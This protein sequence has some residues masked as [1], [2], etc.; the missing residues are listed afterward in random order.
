MKFIFLILFMLVSKA[1]FSQESR[2]I[3]IEWEPVEDAVNYEVELFEEEND[4]KTPRGKFKVESSTWSNAVPPGKYSLRIRSLDKRGVP[5]EW[6]EFIPVKVRMQNPRLFQPVPGSKINTPE[7]NF[8][9]SE[10]D[11]AAS[12]QLVVKNGEGKIVHNNLVKDLR[13]SLYLDDLGN[14]SWV[15][16]ALEENEALRPEEEFLASGFKPFSRVGGELDPPE[17]KVNV[18]GKVSITWQKI[19]GARVYEVDYLPPADSDKSRR[20][21]LRRESFAFAANRLREGVTTITFKST[22]PGYPDSLKTVVQL[23]RS[24]KKIEIQDIIQGKKEEKDRVSPASLRWKNELFASMTLA[25][26]KYSSTEIENDTRLD[27]KELTGVGVGLEWVNKPKLN[28]L[29]RKTEF[30][31]LQLTSGRETGASVRAA[32][33]LNGEKFYRTGRFTY[34]GGLN[35]LRLPAFMGNRFEDDIFVEHSLSLGPQLQLG[36]SAA[37]SNNWG[38]DANA[39]Y[40]QQLFYLNSERDGGNSFPWLAVNSRF[41]YYITKKEAIFA[42]LEYQRWDQKWSSDDSSLGGFSLSLGLK[43]GF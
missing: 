22:A 41:L 39:V 40:S 16:Y 28:S 20:F 1:A 6:S 34:G 21:K 38:W 7:V 25:R 9:W 42:G 2:W 37:L 5:G 15:S 8:E 18:S 11:G 30:S 24:G 10:I 35:L 19:R 14:Y 26:Y 36:Y 27:Q 4:T 43:A 31:Y 23:L 3:D 33:S 17:V 32:F 13:A 12:Y 29:Q